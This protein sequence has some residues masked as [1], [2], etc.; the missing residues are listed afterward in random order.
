MQ[1]CFPSWIGRWGCRQERPGE[2]GRLF[3]IRQCWITSMETTEEDWSRRSIWET[4]TSSRKGHGDMVCWASGDINLSSATK[5]G[6]F[7]KAPF[8]FK[9]ICI[10]FTSFAVCT[11]CACM[12]VCVHM[13][14]HMWVCI[15]VSVCNVCLMNYPSEMGLREEHGALFFL[16]V[17]SSLI[18][19]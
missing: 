3:C 16:Q 14:L 7:S 17:V 13:C 2:G 1:T 11:V 19:L 15:C 18:M 4:G 10:A 5:W 12:F 8:V 9:K 6:A